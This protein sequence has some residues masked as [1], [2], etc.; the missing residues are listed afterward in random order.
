MRSF[1]YIG[2]LF[3]FGFCFSCNE[4]NDL[5]K[6]QES[7]N[8]NQML[9]EIQTIANS[10]TC[11]NSSEWTFVS[12]GSKACGGP[13]GYIA[14]ATIIDTDDFLKKI[15]EHRAAQKEFNKKWGIISDCSLPSQPS[16]VICENGKPVFR[17]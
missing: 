16:A 15:E 2:I 1:N 3:L 13:V 5:M 6:E 11:N 14:Y 12:Y 8:L 9:S 4:N 17:Y 7:Q 10:K